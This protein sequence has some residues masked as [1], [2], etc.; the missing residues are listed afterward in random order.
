MS[1]ATA[2]AAYTFMA[3]TYCPE[4]IVG[5]VTSRPEFEGWGLAAGI[6]MPVEKN[7]DEIAAAF[8]FDRSDERTFDGDEFPKVAFADQLDNDCCGTCGEPL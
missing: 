4:H 5:V 1:V 7:L 6:T 3:D 8:G 2:P